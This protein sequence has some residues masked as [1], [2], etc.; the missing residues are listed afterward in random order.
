[1]KNLPYVL[2]ALILIAFGINGCKKSEL[3]AVPKN[4]LST[5]SLSADSSQKLKLTATQ[6]TT[7]KYR[8]DTLTISGL[9]ASDTVH[10]SITPPGHTTILEKSR[11]RYIVSFELGG[12]YK[13]KA[14]V[15]GTDTL[16]ATIRVDTLSSTSYTYIPFAA[17]DQ[18][19]VI[20]SLYKSIFADSTYIAFT[21]QTTKT[22]PC[23]NS[24]IHS[25]WGSDLNN[26][27]SVNFIDIEQ[28]NDSLCM[29]GPGTLAVNM[30][31][32]QKAQNPYMVNGTYPL[33]ITFKGT[34]YKGSIKVSPHDIKFDWNYTSG[35]T[36]STKKLSR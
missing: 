10:W 15:N 11:S 20:P 22:Y 3:P 24:L 8:P 32:L 35:V 1:M 19:L 31:F 34:I 7:T 28:P 2:F 36:F 21:A 30:P 14:I 25:S 26:N 9:S 17:G 18:I 6:L 23:V 12:L 5:N 29:N 13:I 16:S 4:K 33:A 27:F